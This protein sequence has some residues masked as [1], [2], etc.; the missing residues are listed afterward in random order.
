MWW[1]SVVSGS[2]GAMV[3]GMCAHVAGGQDYFL[4]LAMAQVCGVA[5]GARNG[6]NVWQLGYCLV[7]AQQQH[8]TPCYS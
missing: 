8:G 6:A 1:E 3:W 7:L 2:T 4:R 5:P